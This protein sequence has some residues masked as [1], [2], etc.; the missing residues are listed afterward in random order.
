MVQTEHQVLTAVIG[1]PFKIE[2]VAVGVP[3]PV[4]KWFKDSISINDAIENFAVTD[5]VEVLDGGLTKINSTLSTAAIGIEDTGHYFCF[6]TN[7]FGT[8]T[9][10]VADLTVLGEW[11]KQVALLVGVTTISLSSSTNN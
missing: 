5:M 8:E 9:Q 2:C 6:A 10:E 4:I 11:L 1:Y 3:V 7:E